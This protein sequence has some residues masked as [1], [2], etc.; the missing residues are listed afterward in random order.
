MDL[1]ELIYN[2][3]TR[4]KEGFVQSEIDQLLTKFPDI[5]MDKFNNAL[6]GITCIMDDTGDLVIYHV[7]VLH[8]L[9]CGIDDRELEF[10]EWD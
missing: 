2:F 9:Q 5:N 1:K 6:N 7:D 10:F 3:K 4:N 8:A